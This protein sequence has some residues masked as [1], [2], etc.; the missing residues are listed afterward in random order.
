MS[1]DKGLKILKASIKNFKNIE[2]REVE[3]NGK[4]AVIVGPN[5]AGKSS[6]IQAI[7]S[8][9][10]SKMIPAEPVKSGEH[11]AEVI[12]TIGG[13]LHGE[14][15]KYKISCFFSEQNKRGKIIL[16]NEEGIEIS[17]A[18]SNLQQ[19][20]GN[21]SFDIMEFMRLAKTDSGKISEAGVKKQIELVKS[22]MP[23]DVLKRLHELDT[24]AK[25]KYDER[26]EINREIKYIKSHI[27]Q[28]RMTSDEFE[29]YKEPTS[30]ADILKQIE[31][32]EAKNAMYNKAKDF[33]K[34]FP[35]RNID[36]MNEVESL[37][38]RY[39][40]PDK[41]KELEKLFFSLRT[42]Q[43]QK[44]IAY[45]EKNTLIDVDSLKSKLTEVDEHNRKHNLIQ[46]ILV[47][48]KQLKDKEQ[49]SKDLTAIIESCNTEKVELFEKANLPV[50]GLSFND[51]CVTYNGLPLTEEQH[52]TS[53]LIAIGLEIG[54]ALNPNLR[55]LVIKDGSLLDEKSMKYI[56]KTCEERGYQLLVE[57]VGESDGKDVVVEFIEQ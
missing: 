16:R 6:L 4:S 23:K 37:I 34:D 31:E 1:E 26:T 43:Q 12:L 19:I 44:C 5:G 22:L 46:E 39:D 45:T 18:K 30:S 28:N 47:K 33:I 48:E 27:D 52:P 17:G 15:V 25:E 24:L 13:N 9:V 56:L 20:I 41:D 40:I 36:L 35:T 54:M 55:L 10:N 7:C 42:K 49:L 21:I 3:F 53:R 14:K 32:A 8:P 51:E 11:Q 50:K 57:K 2:Y 29:K 38:Y